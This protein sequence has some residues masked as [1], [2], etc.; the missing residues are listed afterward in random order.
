AL[1]GTLAIALAFG[2]AACS[3]DPSGPD[4]GETAQLT[5]SFTGPG[6]GGTPESV[7]PTSGELPDAASASTLR[8]RP[9]VEL[10]GANGTLT[11]DEM[12]IV[13]SG[14]AMEEPDGNCSGAVGCARFDG[15]PVATPLPL[16]DESLP[17]AQG[18]IAAGAYDELT[19]EVEDL[20]ADEPGDQEKA[21]QLADL[22][23]EVRQDVPDWPES[24]AAYVT[25]QFTPTGGEPVEFRTFL[26]AEATV[27][28]SFAAPLAISDEDSGDR[29]MVEVTPAAWFAGEEVV[30]LSAHDFDLTGDVVSFGELE[31]AVS[32]GFTRV[33]QEGSGPAVSLT[34]P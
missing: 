3:D 10:G 25:G 1:V 19:F 7:A 13:V 17:V 18:S 4:G 14:F 12:R 28:L 20:E 29:M 32:A 23:E 9:S 6:V 22:L 5:V 8:V 2:L 21:D 34:T 30:D 16:T 26:E 31:A 15:P 27:S 11:I 33:F 24:A